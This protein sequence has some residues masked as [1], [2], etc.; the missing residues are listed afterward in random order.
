MANLS[1]LENILKS[2]VDI[3]NKEQNQM[4]PPKVFDSIINT[5][6]SFYKSALIKAY[7]VG[8]DVLRPF[9]RTKQV[10]VKNGLVELP[11]DYRD[12][13][14]NPSI[15][16]KNDGTAECGDQPDISDEDQFNLEILKK[17]CQSRPIDMLS[18]NEWD[19]R[20]TSKY[21][22]PTYWDPIGCFFDEK[23]I[24]VCPYDIAVVNVRYAIEEKQYRYGY[25]IQPDDTYI[26]DKNT[27]IE[28]E[29]KDNAF[30]ALFRGC[31]AL[32]SDY[33]RDNQLGQAS[34]ILNQIGLF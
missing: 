18:Q 30:P 25:I 3:G 2:L 16:A 19:D 17:G 23:N 10:N 13:I 7:P 15:V 4:L 20:T 27:S 12:M 8:A 6:S 28:S 24:K 33:L 32:Y 9:M 11:S 21:K 14:G 29:W 22:Q 5:V 26:Y 34:Q 31:L 1:S